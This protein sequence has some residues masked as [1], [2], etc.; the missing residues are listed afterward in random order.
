[1]GLCTTQY[2][3]LQ[4]L[5]CG[6]PTKERNANIEM[7][8]CHPLVPYICDA[9]FALLVVLLVRKTLKDEILNVLYFVSVLSLHTKF[10]DFM[11]LR[12]IS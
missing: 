9:F 12:K 8:I 7:S 5:S 10:T 4:K 11:I 6:I 3:M 2:K 1:M